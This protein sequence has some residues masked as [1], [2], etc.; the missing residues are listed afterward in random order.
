MP[1]VSPFRPVAHDIV[2]VAASVDWTLHN[3]FYDNSRLS[4]LATTTPAKTKK[5]KQKSPAPNAPSPSTRKEPKNALHRPSVILDV[6]ADN[7]TVAIFATLQ[8]KKLS[9]VKGIIRP[10]MAEVLPVG[11][12]N[13]HEG[14][15]SGWL[16]TLQVSPT[17]RIPD[18]A[19]HSVCLCIK[20]QVPIAKLEPW[21]WGEEP[22]MVGQRYRMCKADFKLLQQLC[23]RNESLRGLFASS[24]MGWL[25]EELRLDDFVRP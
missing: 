18:K 13:N 14:S 2:R 12:T 16:H 21:S 15:G 17:W 6:S 1:P 5:Q 23:Q 19:N 10:I 25:F 3:F 4:A 7:A 9:E 20:H 11:H 8:G 22:K 24:E